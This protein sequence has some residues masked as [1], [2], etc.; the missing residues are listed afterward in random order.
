[1]LPDASKVTGLDTTAVTDAEPAMTADTPDSPISILKVAEA[2]SVVVDTVPKL[3]VA[4]TWKVYVMAGSS[5]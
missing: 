2:G 4:V 1:M 3:A 5:L